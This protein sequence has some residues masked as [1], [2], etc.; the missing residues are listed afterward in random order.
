MVVRVSVTGQMV[1]ETAMVTTVVT[2][3]LAGQ[4]GTVGA[5]EVMVWMLVV[6][7]VDVLS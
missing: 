7:T 1:V 6:K 3:E 4:S 5:H 2:T